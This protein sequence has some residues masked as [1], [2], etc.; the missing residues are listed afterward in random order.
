[1]DKV[2]MNSI[3][4][5]IV[6]VGAG[7]G[8]EFTH[9]QELIPMKYKEAVAGPEK[10]EWLKAVEEEYQHMVK[11]KVFKEVHKTDVPKNAKILS[12]TWAMKK[13]ANGTKRARINAR[14]YEQVNGEHF[15]SSSMASPVVNEASMFFILITICMARMATDENDVKGA[16]LNGKFS[17]GEQ[18]Y[19]EV[20][21]GFERFFPSNVVLLLLKNIYGLKQAAF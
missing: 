5:K 6:T 14:G 21:E 12:S 11:Y 19:M 1:M 20:P 13:K 2:M 3:A 10:V 18:L 15:N 9:T 16:F 7:I 17:K 4:N 8:G